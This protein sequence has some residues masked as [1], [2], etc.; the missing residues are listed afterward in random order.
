MPHC[1]EPTCNLGAFEYECPCC[2]Y[3]STDYEV[4]FAQDKILD[5]HIKPFLCENCN[6]ELNVEWNKKEY[7]YEVFKTIN[8]NQSDEK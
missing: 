1:D 4:W 8:K 6:A 7:K 5:G 2:G 3:N